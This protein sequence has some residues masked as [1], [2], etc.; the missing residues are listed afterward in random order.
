[1]NES[2]VGPEIASVNT[3]SDN[4]TSGILMFENVF[5]CAN[6]VEL[7]TNSLLRMTLKVFASKVFIK[8]YNE[9]CGIR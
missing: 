9:L 5:F 6:L 4:L 8:W 7:K 2:Y 1:M 3:P